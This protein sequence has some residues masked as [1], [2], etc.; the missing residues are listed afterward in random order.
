MLLTASCRKYEFVTF[1]LVCV[2]ITA[3]LLESFQ[4]PTPSEDEEIVVIDKFIRKY[5][6][7]YNFDSDIFK[8]ILIMNI[9]CRV[10][11]YATTAQEQVIY[12]SKKPQPLIPPIIHKIPILPITKQLH[13]F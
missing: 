7:S 6:R 3:K 9:D 4:N 2:E 13:E 10:L 8:K 11:N 12:I 5:S 1:I